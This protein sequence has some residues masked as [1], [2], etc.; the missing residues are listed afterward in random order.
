MMTEKKTKEELIE[1]FHLMWDLYPEQVRLID[2]SFLVIAGNAAYI[3]AGGQAGVHCN[4][5]DPAMHRGCRAMAALNAGETMV[6]KADVGGIQ[7]ESF[8]VPVAGE[9][10]YYIHFTNG[11]NASI[12]QY[13]QSQS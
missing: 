12:Q 8:W 2:R 3:Q 13:L 1:A 9:D 7:W 4:V 5:G 6:T 10:D 11:L